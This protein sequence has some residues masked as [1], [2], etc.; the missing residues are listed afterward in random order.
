MQIEDDRQGHARK[1]ERNQRRQKIKR[2]SI[3]L[4]RESTKQQQTER[5]GQGVDRREESGSV[6]RKFYLSLEQMNCETTKTPA[7]QRNR[8]RDE[9]EVIPDAGGIDAS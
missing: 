9:C 6:C 2:Q 8:N 7:K 5:N 4:E 3:N 1:K